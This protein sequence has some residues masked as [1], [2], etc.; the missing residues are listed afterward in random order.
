MP[1]K[2]ARWNFFK[3][4]YFFATQVLTISTTTICNISS[5]Y[6]TYHYYTYFNVQKEKGKKL[7]QKETNFWSTVKHSNLKKKKKRDTILNY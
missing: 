6:F 4:K 1:N 2:I 5:T 7:Q 3:I